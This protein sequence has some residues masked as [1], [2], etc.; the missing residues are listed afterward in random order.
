MF[1][2]KDIKEAHAKVKSGADFPAYIQELIKLG[3]IKYDS[4]VNDG[5]TI[6]FGGADYKVQSESKYSVLAV[7]DKS[8]PES[9]KKYLKIHQQGQ[10]DYLT[11]C[12]HSAEAGIEK[13]TVD[14]KN[15]TCTYFDKANNK[16]LEEKIP[17][18]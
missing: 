14:M 8:D 6:F 13:W 18:V 16:I 7:S 10:T 3:V 11:F 1:L 5:H 15:M 12:R 4:F 2:L 9:F 17:A